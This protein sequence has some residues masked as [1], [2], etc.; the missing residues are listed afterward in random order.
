[1]EST[2]DLSPGGFNVG[3]SP[4]DTAGL[5]LGGNAGADPVDFPNP[6]IVSLAT[7]ELFDAAGGSLGGPFDITGF[8]NFTAGPGGGWDGGVGVTFGAGSAGIGIAAYDLIVEYNMVPEPT[9]MLTCLFGLLGL[10]W[11]RRR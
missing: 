9:S 4:A 2:D 10:G 8:A 5:F 6:A 1:V 11:V 3:G 7:V